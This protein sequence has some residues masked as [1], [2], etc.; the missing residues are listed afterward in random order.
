[1]QRIYILKITHNIETIDSTFVDKELN[2]FALKYNAE[3]SNYD[4]DT[5]LDNITKKL[6]IKNV[7]YEW[8]FTDK[9]NLQNFI[10][11]LPKTYKIKS[12][13]RKN[14]N[15]DIYNIFVHNA[16]PDIKKFIED[17]KEL[18]MF[19]LYKLKANSIIHST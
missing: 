11:A 10:N 19:G 17:D 4:L 14:S 3:Y 1:M 8:N 13:Q 9:T 18:Y 7:I 6:E 5:E 12:I 15:I 2:E 16:C